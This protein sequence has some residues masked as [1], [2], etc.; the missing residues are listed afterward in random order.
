MR[1]AE[2]W[3]LI[4]VNV[5]PIQVT[6]PK[7]GGWHSFKGGR[8]FVRVWYIHIKMPTQV[9]NCAC[10]YKCTHTNI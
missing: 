5:D 4:R 8:S 7:V 2:G 3:A 9:H 1:L 10:T 6:E